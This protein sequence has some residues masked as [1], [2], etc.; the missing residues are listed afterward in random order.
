MTWDILESGF[1][2]IPKVLLVEYFH[3]WIIINTK[4]AVKK[5]TVSLLLSQT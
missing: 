2:L 3:L 1:P 5:P 4:K